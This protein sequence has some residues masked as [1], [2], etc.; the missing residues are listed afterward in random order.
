MS[1][2][3]IMP[4]SVNGVYRLYMEVAERIVISDDVL[5]DRGIT[6]AFWPPLPLITILVAFWH[7]RLLASFR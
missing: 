7:T 2:V 3:K 6:R 1:P 4:S 5:L